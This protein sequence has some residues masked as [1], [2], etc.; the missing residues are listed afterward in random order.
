LVIIA[1]I[2][3]LGVFFDIPR[4]ASVRALESCVC[5]VLSREDFNQVKMNFPVI[6]ERFQKV[7]N[8]RLDEIN[9]QGRLKKRGIRF[10]VEERDENDVEEK[11]ENEV[12][13]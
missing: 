9:R 5:S 3:E 8:Q 2:G 11:D 1:K 4:T 6:Q 10:V 12:E 13:E 7:V